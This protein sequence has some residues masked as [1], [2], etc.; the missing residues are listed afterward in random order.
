MVRSSL[1][2]KIFASLT[3]MICAENLVEPWGGKFETLETRKKKTLGKR[4]NYFVKLRAIPCWQ[5]VAWVS[6]GQR[7]VGQLSAP[8]Y[9]PNPGSRPLRE[10]RKAHVGPCGTRGITDMRD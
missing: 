7:S 5:S 3:K 2:G 1:F 6:L 10:A 4:W 8:H 9:P